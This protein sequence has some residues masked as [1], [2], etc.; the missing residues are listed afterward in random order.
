MNVNVNKEGKAS[1]RDLIPEQ[2][3]TIWF[4]LEALKGAYQASLIEYAESVAGLQ[5]EDAVF[6]YS[7]LA[8]VTALQYEMMDDYMEPTRTTVREWFYV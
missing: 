1:F 5:N 2:G 3:R 6:L 4:A 8:A 7:E